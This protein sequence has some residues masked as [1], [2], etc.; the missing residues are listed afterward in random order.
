MAPADPLCSGDNVDIFRK[1]GGRGFVRRRRALAVIGACAVMAA[2]SQPGPSAPATAATP[3]VPRDITSPTLV[4]A[5]PANRQPMPSFSATAPPIVGG[6]RE[7]IGGDRP[8]TLYVPEADGPVPLLMLLHV[9]GGSGQW[10]EDYWR[11]G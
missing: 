10:Q 11:L 1:T 8:T 4:T 5:A 9:F 6:R 3:N 2:C 7:T